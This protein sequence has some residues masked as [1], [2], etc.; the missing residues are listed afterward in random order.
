MAEPTQI[1]NEMIARL[2]ALQ[3]SGEYVP[4]ARRVNAGA[5]LSGGGELSENVTVS[6]S[7]ETRAEIQDRV[8]RSEWENLNQYTQQQEQ[9]IQAGFNAVQESITAATSGA[10][11]QVS[12]Q[13]PVRISVGNI[14]EH[15]E[16]AEEPGVLYLLFEED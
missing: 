6:L 7:A 14:E 16:S 10:I 8:T 11:R 4:L 13:S 12:G 3:G 1:V 9:A 2:R 5:G 15:D